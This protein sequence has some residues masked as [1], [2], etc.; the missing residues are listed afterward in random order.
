M[1]LKERAG[2]YYFTLDKSCAE[3]VL[4]AAN[5]VYSLGLTEA[6][7]GL[8]AGFRTGMGCGSTCGGLSGAIG[9]LSKKYGQ[10]EDFK[11]LCARFVDAFQTKLACGSIDCATLAARYKTEAGRCRAAVE[12]TAE[13]LEEFID[14][15]EGKPAAGGEDCTLRPE[16]IKRV[17][18]L[19]FLQHKGTNKFNG[20]IITRNGRITDEECRVIAEAAKLYGDGHMMFTTRLTV[21]VSGIDYQD[22]DAFRAYVGKVGLETGGTGSKVRPVVSCKGTTCQYGL[23]DTYAL[24]NEIHDRFYK[25]YRD[26]SLPHKF[27]IAVGGCPN[28]CVKPDLNDLGIV[29]A[30]VPGYDADQ[31]RGCKICQLE[32]SCPIHAA[33]LVDGKLV[34]DPNL[35]NSCGRCV[36][37]CPFH[38]NDEGAYGWKIFVGGRWGKKVA[39]GKM[40][41]KIF[42]DKEEVMAVVEKA[43]LL[44]RDQGKSGERFADTIDRIGFENAQE[45]LLGDGL[46]KRKAEILGLNVVGGASC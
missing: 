13:A 19:G 43:I 39:H 33:K 26:V 5:E 10:R 15:L 37:K 27:K 23:Y 8:F 20:R 22:I 42:T 46:L 35:C 30:R 7:I 17:K 21:E 14:G 6:E 18:G 45:Q 16:D 40:L 9:V 36:G 3:A 11:E 34:I 44:F 28:N 4:L 29:G 31:C 12:L 2:Y 32:K 41:N 24:S 38:C 1:S 25:G